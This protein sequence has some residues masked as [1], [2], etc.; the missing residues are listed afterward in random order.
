MFWKENETSQCQFLKKQDL[1]WLGQVTS[2]QVTYQV[3][4]QTW[5]SSFR[6]CSRMCLGTFASVNNWSH[7]Y[8]IIACVPVKV[9]VKVF[10]A[11]ILQ[12]SPVCFA[13][14]FSLWRA[15]SP[16]HVQ[17]CFF[18]F[19]YFLPLFLIVCL[20]SIMIRRL[21]TQVMI[22][23]SEN[24]TVPGKIVWFWYVYDMSQCTMSPLSNRMF[25]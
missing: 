7:L 9:K 13:F 3:T 11:K 6:D 19:G 18:I 24:R 5:K 14:A 16:L 4:S 2:H 1:P 20:Y 21:L 17:V 12:K 25:L 23:G 15:S 10:S 8:P 22:W